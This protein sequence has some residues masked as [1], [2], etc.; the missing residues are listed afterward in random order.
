MVHHQGRDY[1]EGAV[2]SAGYWVVGCKKLVS[3]EIYNCVICRKLRGR[4]ENQKMADLPSVRVQ[5][6]PPFTY[7]GVDMFGHWEVVTRKT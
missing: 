7:I 1:T 3:S 2:R 4:L 6:S 5:Q